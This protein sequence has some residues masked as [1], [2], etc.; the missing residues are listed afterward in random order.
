MLSE[1]E[2]LIVAVDLARAAARMADMTR[3]EAA[4]HH[5]RSG[6][7]ALEDRLA[8]VSAELDAVNTELS[9]NLA[10]SAVT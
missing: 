1:A 9:A 10:L 7:G 8:A 2:L 6:V 4:V 3:V 5:L